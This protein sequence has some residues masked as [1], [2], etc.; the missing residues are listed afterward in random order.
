MN[1]SLFNMGNKQIKLAFSGCWQHSIWVMMK[2][3]NRY[4]KE[5]TESE[6]NVNLYMRECN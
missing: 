1:V 6:L 3:T 4:N 2:H 5:W